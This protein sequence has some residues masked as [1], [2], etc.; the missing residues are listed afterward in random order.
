[1]LSYQDGSVSLPE[2]S[3]IIEMKS[4]GIL[5]R[6]TQKVSI[7]GGKTQSVKVAWPGLGKLTVQA[8]PSNCRIFV[9]GMDLGAPPLLNQAIVAGDHEVRVVPEGHAD[10]A[11]VKKVTIE[12]GV[13][14]VEPFSFN[15]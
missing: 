7:T 15:F 9:D 3:H 10:Q 6:A 8:E 4:P 13:T 5:Y 1:K 12:E 14:K 2:G 11:R